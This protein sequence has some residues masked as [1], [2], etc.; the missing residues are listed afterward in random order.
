[1]LDVIHNKKFPLTELQGKL[2]CDFHEF[3]SQI[4]THSFQTS[5]LILIG[6]SYD[7]QICLVQH[8]QYNDLD[9]HWEFWGSNLGRN[10]RTSSFPTH[11]DQLQR[12]LSL[13]LNEN[14]SYFSGSKVASADSLTTQTVL[15]ASIK[16]SA[17]IPPPNLSANT[18]HTGTTLLHL[19]PYLCT[20][21]S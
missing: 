21:L 17:T 20:Y 19:Y 6:L 18:A 4:K 10:K 3:L 15:E 13:Q 14:Q 9:I 2:P 7:L 12:P 5:H 8:S 11:P 16:I 1:M